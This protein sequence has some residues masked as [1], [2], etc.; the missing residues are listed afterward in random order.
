MPIT[1]NY[2][3]NADFGLIITGY[4]GA[5]LMAGSF[6]AIGGFFSSLTKNQ[7]ISFI[8]SVAALAILV[9]IGMPTTLNYLS[10]NPC[11]RASSLSRTRH[12]L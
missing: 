7:V 5:I 8:L 2:L 4:I 12:I 10:S 1:V 11:K 9:Y 3:G 6:L